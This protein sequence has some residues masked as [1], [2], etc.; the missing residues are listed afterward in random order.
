MLAWKDFLYSTPSIVKRQVFLYFSV[1]IPTSCCET[2][3]GQANHNM[4]VAVPLAHEIVPFLYGWQRWSGL[5]SLWTTCSPDQYWTSP[6]APVGF[7]LWR[8]RS[9][10]LWLTWSSQSRNWA[11]L[12]LSMKRYVNFINCIT[13]KFVNY[14]L[15]FRFWNI[16]C[17]IFYKNL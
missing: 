3:H 10:A 7:S 13:H 8:V 11:V 5:C 9:T 17:D 4:R 6:G 14:Q 15:L 12:S 1:L 16:L 2:L